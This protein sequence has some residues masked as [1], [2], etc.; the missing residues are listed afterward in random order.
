M[1][2]A[3]HREGN[4]SAGRGGPPGYRIHRP[5]EPVAGLQDP[6]RRSVSC[7]RGTGRTD[8]PLAEKMF[9]VSPGAVM[10]IPFRGEAM[11]RRTFWVAILLV[12]FS[13]FGVHSVR[14]ADPYGSTGGSMEQT[15]SPYQ[16]GMGYQGTT[17]S[18]P[19][20]PGL[21]SPYPQPSSMPPF[22]RGRAPPARVLPRRW[23]RGLRRGWI[24]CRRNVSPPSSNWFPGRWRS[25]GRSSR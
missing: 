18:Y 24:H 17:G 11:I 9:P 8:H 15:P 19:M 20:A 10:L 23:K 22:P 2:C 25:R 4:V 21:Q 7:W 14:A 5:M 6:D 16:G 13:L 12:V 1:T 3:I